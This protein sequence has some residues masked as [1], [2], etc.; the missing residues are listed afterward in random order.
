M[1]LVNATNFSPCYATHHS[2]FQSLRLF[3]CFSSV[4]TIFMVSQIV[5][6][7]WSVSFFSNSFLCIMLCFFLEAD[8]ERLD[9]Q[10]GEGAGFDVFSHYALISYFSCL[11]SQYVPSERVFPL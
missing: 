6:M 2:A 1:G 4:L 5:H 3:D 7:G 11:S 9:I 10:E 8:L